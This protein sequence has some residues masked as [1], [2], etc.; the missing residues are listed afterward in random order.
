MLV[1]GI[2]Q[3]RNSK[4]LRAFIILQLYL[5]KQTITELLS[6]LTAWNGGLV[7]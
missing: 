6:C 2:L 3:G 1:H 7:Y 4:R 5:I